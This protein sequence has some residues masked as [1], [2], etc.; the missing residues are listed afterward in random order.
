MRRGEVWWAELPETAG[1]RPVVVLTRDTAIAVRSLV[2][3]APLTRTVHGLPAEVALGED[4]GVLKPCVVNCDG[5]LTVPKSFLDTRLTALEPD[6]MRE[7]ERAV[8]YALDL[9]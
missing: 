8:K 9:T 6:K 2:T 7:V 3:I 4:D 1:R 5:L